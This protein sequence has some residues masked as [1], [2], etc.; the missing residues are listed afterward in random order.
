MVVWMDGIVFKVRVSGKIINNTV[1]QCF[2]LNNRGYKEVLGMWIGKAESSSFYI[3][4]QI[5]LNIPQFIFN[6]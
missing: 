1:Y 6:V 2:G 3:P 5:D 4:V